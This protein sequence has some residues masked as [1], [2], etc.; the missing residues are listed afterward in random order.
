M[1][2]DD[3]LTFRQQ[4]FVEEVKQGGSLRQAALRA[5]YTA[6]TAQNANRDILT[7]PA[8]AVTLRQLMS[9][10]EWAKAVDSRLKTIVTQG[11]ESNAIKASELYAKVAG[12]IAPEQHDVTVFTAKDRDALYHDVSNLV[13]RKMGQAAQNTITLSSE[14]QVTQCVTENGE[15]GAAPEPLLFGYSE[16]DQQDHMDTVSQDEVGPGGMDT[17]QDHT[18]VKAPISVEEDPEF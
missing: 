17:P 2:E 8:V 15:T 5:G 10:P 18:L 16:D 6:N 3:K 11:K 7:K 14:S 12:Q 9:T 13:Q 1:A 4:R